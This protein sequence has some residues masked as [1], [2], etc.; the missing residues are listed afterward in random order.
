MFLWLNQP[1]ANIIQ[2][3]G[4]TDEE[5]ANKSALAIFSRNDK[6]Y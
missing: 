6:V 4:N 2:N 1:A 5:Y 3:R